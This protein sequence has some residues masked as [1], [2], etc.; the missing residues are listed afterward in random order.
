MPFV[1]TEDFDATCA[2]A[3]SAAFWLVVTAGASTTVGAGVCAALT[4][5][6][7]VGALRREWR[8]PTVAFSGRR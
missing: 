3:G 8:L 4:L 7:R 1:L 5:L 6:L 2:V